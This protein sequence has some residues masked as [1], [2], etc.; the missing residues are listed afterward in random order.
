LK[1]S[2]YTTSPRA[3][4]P[5]GGDEFVILLPGIGGES[6]LL[7]RAGALGDAV[8]LPMEIGGQQLQVGLSGGDEFVVLLSG[9]GDESTLLV[10]AEALAAAVGKPMEIGAQAVR[11]GLSIGAVL[12][13]HHTAEAGGMLSGAD[14]A[15]YA[16]KQSGGGC[17]LSRVAAPG[18]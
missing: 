1:D 10:R 18:S 5:R 8:A 9:I 15:M 14:A 3:K 4:A 11:V 12:V 6:T 2:V 13:P 7:A 16:A 17:R